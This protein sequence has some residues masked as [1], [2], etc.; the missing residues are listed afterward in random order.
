MSSLDSEM[1]FRFLVCRSSDMGGAVARVVGRSGVRARFA[2]V[3][4]MVG[5]LDATCHA[6]ALRDTSVA[7]TNSGS[8]TPLPFMVSPNCSQN[9]H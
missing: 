4:I 8:L 1:S 5:T 2:R 7:Q 9:G 6:H 3:V